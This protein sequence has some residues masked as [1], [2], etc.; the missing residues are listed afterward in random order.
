MALDLDIVIIAEYISVLFRSGNSFIVVSGGYQ[1]RKFP[2]ETRRAD[3]KSF[4]MFFQHLKINA[5][6]IIKVLRQFREADELVQIE[7]A[8]LI[9]A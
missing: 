4:F 3:D 8:L 9:L 2:D 5:G 7:S 1:P 6:L